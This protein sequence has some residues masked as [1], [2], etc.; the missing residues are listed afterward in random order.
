VKKNGAGK[1]IHLQG[2]I[3]NHV[4][5]VDITI[6]LYYYCEEVDYNGEDTEYPPWGNFVGRFFKTHEYNSLPSVER[7]QD[8]SNQDK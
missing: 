6:V 5:I 4:L 8:R 2:K 7:D 1:N 3:K